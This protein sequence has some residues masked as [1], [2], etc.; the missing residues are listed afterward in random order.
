MIENK[1]IKKWRHTCEI[2]FNVYVLA[3]KIYYDFTIF[4]VVYVP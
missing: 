1:D 2:T 4:Y 3:R